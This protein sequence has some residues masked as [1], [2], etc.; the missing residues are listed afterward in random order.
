MWDL[1]CYCFLGEGDQRILIDRDHPSHIREAALQIKKG[2]IVFVEKIGQQGG[3]WIKSSC[4]LHL[5]EFVVPFIKNAKY[6]EPPLPLDLPQRQ[7]MAI[8][9]PLE[10]AWW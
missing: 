6:C 2:P 1:P 10:A 4:G 5:S 9:D 7:Q 3:Q 8:H